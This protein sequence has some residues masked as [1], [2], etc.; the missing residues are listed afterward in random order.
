MSLIEIKPGLQQILERL[1]AAG[2]KPMI[3]GG[4]VRDAILG[5]HNPKDID[6]EV[7]GIPYD[8][9]VTAIGDLGHV[10]IIGKAFQ[11]VMARVDGESYDISLPR[12][13]SKV[14]DGHRGF[15]V[16]VDHTMDFTTAS[17]RRDFT[18]NAIGFDPV[19][20]WVTDPHGGVD[21]LRNSHLRH[22][23]DQFGEDPLRVLRGMQ[24]A[25][26]FGMEMNVATVRMCKSLFDEYKTLSVERIWGE[27]EKFLSKGEFLEFGLDVLEQTGWVEHYPELA[28]LRGVPQD[29]GWHP[30]GDVWAHTREAMSVLQS[31][32]EED[33]LIVNLAVL[34]HDFG[35]VTNTQT[36]FPD[37]K[38]RSQGH[39]HAGVEPAKSFLH[40][41]GA[42]GHVIANV[43]PLVREHMCIIDK[44]TAKVA[45]RLMRRLQPATMDQF[46]QVGIA[47]HLGRGEAASLESVGPWI[48]IKDEVEL[49]PERLKPILKGEMLI[50]MG[51]KPG[52]DFRTIINASI[53]AQDDGIIHDA[54]SA[55]QWLE[56]F[57]TDAKAIKALLS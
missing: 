5:D 21:D 30:E 52:P 47:D 8:E 38:I 55:R 16:E 43:L 39:D 45:R 23:N 17:A 48:K 12:R 18:I 27:W 42:P 6:I 3:V 20:H 56:E 9:V 24:F 14:G 50:E 32:L 4:A 2:G 25:A 11:V 26:R 40:R 15:T 44:P 33:R 29:P 36:W 57:L 34:C 35:K 53:E 7:Y 49:T 51:M 31:N 19:N 28:W 10:D 46:I 41:I 22:I 1:T 54:D 37:G 13:D